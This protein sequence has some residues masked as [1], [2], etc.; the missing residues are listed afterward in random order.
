MQRYVVISWDPFELQSFFDVVPAVSKD[1]AIKRA[2]LLRGHYADIV[3]AKTVEA[4]YQF[5]EELQSLSNAKCESLLHEI[6]TEI[7]INP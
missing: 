7:A 6:A 2:N 1:A 4:F 3:D 5:A